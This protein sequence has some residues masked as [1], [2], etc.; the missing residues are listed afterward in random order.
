MT[1]P[2]FGLFLATVLSVSAHAQTP[3]YTFSYTSLRVGDTLSVPALRFV[4]KVADF[5]R[6]QEEW[7]DQIDD[8]ADD[9]DERLNQLVATEIEIPKRS[10]MYYDA[11]TTCT[12]LFDSAQVIIAF[13]DTSGF[14]SREQ[15]TTMTVLET[16]SKRFVTRMYRAYREHYYKEA[17]EALDDAKDKAN[18][19]A[20]DIESNRDDQRSAERRIRELGHRVEEARSRQVSIS[21]QIAQYRQ[22]L[23]R[24]TTE[25]DKSNAQ[26]QIRRLERET[27]RLDSDI[28]SDERSKLEKEEKLNQLK[29]ELT[30]LE[31]NHQTARN[32]QLDAQ[33]EFDLIRSEMQSYRIE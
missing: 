8:V 11:F 29:F 27:D 22:T 10:R 15:K 31:Q 25:E 3:F 13:R 26:D 12:D 20:G 28:R 7:E 21:E 19:I 14:I 17:E 6:F 9:T 23:A 1:K 16:A 24:A 30:T 33:R 4:M 18:D 5:E 2:I 32:A